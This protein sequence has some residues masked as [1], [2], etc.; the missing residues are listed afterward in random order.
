MGRVVLLAPIPPSTTIFCA[1]SSVLKT[2]SCWGA[3]PARCHRRAKRPVERPNHK[4]KAKG[5]G[6][7]PDRCFWPL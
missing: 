4:P 6:L 7:E 3:S 1:A 2:M 5:V